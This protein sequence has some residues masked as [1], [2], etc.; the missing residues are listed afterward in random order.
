MLRFIILCGALWAAPLF[1]QEPAAANPQVQDGQFRWFLLTETK[2][3]VRA[4]LGQPQMVADFGDDFRS[5]QYR[6]GDTDHDDFSLAVVFRRSTGALVSITRNAESER[7]VDAFFP[8]AE[9]TTH[10]YP[11]AQKPQF[12]V[13]LRRLAGGRILMAMGVSKA[14]QTTGQLVLIRE[15]ELRYFFDWLSNQLQS[16]ENIAGIRG[17]HPVRRRI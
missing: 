16:A 2:D 7:N 17:I 15:S 14:G 13:R 4:A 3:E 6:F 9:T 11:T 12:S 10:F 8:E 1:C 5:W